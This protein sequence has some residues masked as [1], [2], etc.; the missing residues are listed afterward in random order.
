M[1]GIA[2]TQVVDSKWRDAPLN[3]RAWIAV[4]CCDCGLVHGRQFRIRK[5]KLQQRAWRDE[6][7][8]AMV[9]RHMHRRH[10]LVRVPRA[11]LYVLPLRIKQAKKP[12]RNVTIRIK[13]A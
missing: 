7:R 6:K 1:G 10:D 3:S 8:T 12:P 11:N 5:G 2:Y 9:R 13:R 4:A